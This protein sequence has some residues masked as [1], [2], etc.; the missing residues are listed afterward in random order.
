MDEYTVLTDK[1]EKKISINAFSKTILNQCISV[2]TD[3]SSKTG[4]IN[5]LMSKPQVTGNRK[6]FSHPYCCLELITIT[7]PEI[8]N[9]ELY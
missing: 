9:Y 5:K 7:N 4:V 1:H 6:P 2:T 8:S 3:K